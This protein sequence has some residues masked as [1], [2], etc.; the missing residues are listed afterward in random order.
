MDKIDS[1]YE[2]WQGLRP[3]NERKQYLLSQ[4]FTIDYNYNS[5]HIGG[6]ML[7]YGQTEL[8]LLFGEVAAKVGIVPRAVKKQLKQMTDKGYIQRR[9]SDGSWYIF[10]T[11]SV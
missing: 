10:T 6:N 8:L 1:L 11:P 7:T 9:E 3:Q 5:N 2:L 4:R